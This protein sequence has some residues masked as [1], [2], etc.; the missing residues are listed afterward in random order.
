MS[1]CR[2]HL[3]IR[4]ICTLLKWQNSVHFEASSNNYATFD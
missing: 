1:F 4:A 2:S 3:D